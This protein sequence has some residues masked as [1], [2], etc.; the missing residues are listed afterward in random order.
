MPERQRVTPSGG[1]SGTH[2]VYTSKCSSTTEGQQWSPYH[3]FWLTNT[4]SFQNKIFFN[5]DVWEMSTSEFDPYPGGVYQVFN[6][7]AST[8]R[9]HKWRLYAPQSPPDC[10]TCGL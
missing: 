5:G 2:G 4:Y 8:A 1:F 10:S 3:Q 9:E 6:V 7:K